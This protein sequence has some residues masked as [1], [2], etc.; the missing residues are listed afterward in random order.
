MKKTAVLIFLLLLYVF[1]VYSA[2]KNVSLATFNW[3][4][5]VGENLKDKGVTSKIVEEAFRRAGY[6]VTL[7][8]IPWSIVL[9]NLKTR[10]YDAGYPALHD[11]ETAKEY[12]FSNPILERKIGFF[13]KKNREITYHKLTDLKSYKIGIVQSY[14]YSS[15]FEN[16]PYLDKKE[17]LNDRQNLQK[18]LKNKI[19]L[20]LVDN[21]VAQNIMNKDLSANERESIEFIARPLEVKTLHLIV[22]RELQNGRELI[23]DFNTGLDSLKRDGTYK[24]ILREYEFDQ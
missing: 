7:K 19:D 9:T 11:E 8:F 23:K 21:I 4:P 1:P 17:A 18:L 20:A 15:E 3:E 14:V 16:A 13:K 24:K 2:L 6:D 10:Q 5:F 22:S 12:I